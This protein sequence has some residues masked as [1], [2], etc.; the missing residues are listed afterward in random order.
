MDNLR[1]FIGLQLRI[2]RARK[3]LTR[4]S[5]AERS[6]L[7]DQTIANFER[8]RGGSLKN[9]SKIVNA[10]ECQIKTDIFPNEE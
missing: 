10:L 2:E 8:G 5:L 9:L 3:Q 1:E 7:T 6:G 4:R